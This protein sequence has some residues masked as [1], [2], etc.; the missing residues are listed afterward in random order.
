MTCAGQAGFVVLCFF[1]LSSGLVELCPQ[2]NLC[3][4]FVVLGWCVCGPAL[5]VCLVAVCFIYKAGRK[6]F[7]V[8]KLQYRQ[9]TVF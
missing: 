2:Q 9:T 1:S 4:L 7:S 3:T 6:P 5:V 8:K